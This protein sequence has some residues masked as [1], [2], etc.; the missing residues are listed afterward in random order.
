MSQRFF[1][2]LALL[3]TLALA[4]PAAAAIK[5]GEVALT[6]GAGGY[7]FDG[8]EHLDAGPELLVRLGYDITEYVGV[9][10]SFGYV[11]TK[12]TLRKPSS[13]SNR[14]AEA[15]LYRADALLYLMPR[16][17]FVPFLVAGGGV[18]Q[19]IGSAT[20]R[21]RTS[22]LLNAG[23]G[24]KLFVADNVALRGEVRQIGTIDYA[25]HL[26]YEAAVGLTW[27]FGR[28]N[29]PAAAAVPPAKEWVVTAPPE[30]VAAKHPAPAP[31]PAI[32]PAPVAAPAALAETTEAGPVTLTG[33][34]RENAPAGKIMVTG[35]SI[36]QDALEITATGRITNYKTFTLSQPSR[37]VIDINNAVNGLGASRVPVHKFGIL[38]VRFGNHPNFLR[39]VLDA[40]QGKLLP[41]RITETDNGLKVIMSAP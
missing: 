13:A 6:V 39:I 22:A 16:S 27:Y 37:L 1:V 4:M 18:K 32:E 14:Q 35:I 36:D 5:G 30:H 21:N 9:E 40:A 33:T 2:L 11:D 25:K 8:Q 10:G 15:Y 24:A 28:E 12:S 19:E 26:N 23:L 3:V 34:G 17:T 31:A 7:V 20:Y 29:R 41:Y 38:A